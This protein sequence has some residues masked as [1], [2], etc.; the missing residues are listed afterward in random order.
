VSATKTK[1]IA[2]VISN[3]VDDARRYRH[4]S[5]LKKYLPIDEYGE[6]GNLGL[7]DMV[8]LNTIFGTFRPVQ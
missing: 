8:Q 5:E 4:V 1:M 6:C 2:S 7:Y 3:C